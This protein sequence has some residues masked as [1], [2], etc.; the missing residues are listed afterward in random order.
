MLCNARFIGSETATLQSY[1]VGLNVDLACMTETLVQEGERVALLQL[2]PL[3]YSV[4]HQSWTDERGRGG[5]VVS[6]DFHLQGAPSAKH[7]GQ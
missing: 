4:L 6:E 2:I 3:G 7:P 5:I 1:I